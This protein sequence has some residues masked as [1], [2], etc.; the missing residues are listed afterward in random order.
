MAKSQTTLRDERHQMTRRALIKW[1]VAAGA[2][3][4]VS[5][6]KVFEILEKTAGKGVAMAASENPTTRSVHI[7]AGNGALAWFTLF[8]PQVD[9]ANA[10]NPNFAWHKPGQQTTVAGTT[11]PLV[12]G[13]DTPWQKLA[14]AQQVTAFLCGQ[15]ETHN[16]QPKSTATLNGSNIFAVASALQSASPSVIPVVTIGDQSVG[17]AAGQAAVSNVGNADGITALFNSAASRAGGLLSNMN[18]A[19]TYKTYYDAFSQLNRARAQSTVQTSYQTAG[20]AATFLGTNLA[21]KLQVTA[22]DLTRYGVN[23]GTRASL[24]AVARTLIITA[25][26]FQLG[27]TNSVVF[28]AFRDDP[29]NA[30]DGGDVNT[31]PAA[32]KTVFDG[33]MTD[34]TNYT[35]SATGQTLKDDT[36]ISVHG[37]TMKNCRNKAGWGDGTDGNT[38]TVFVYGAGHLYSGWNGSIDRNGKVLGYGTDGKPTTYD[39]NGTAKIA[40]AAIAYAIAKRDDRLIQTFANGTTIGGVFGPLKAT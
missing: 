8:W 31:I 6:A 21:S 13:P 19:T 36:V 39:P 10:G 20:G 9:I 22:D 12:I 28:P 35:D 32:M 30:F 16:N 5:R 27:L 14:P 15:N 3:L 23:A 29:H 38:N 40:T 25:K 34:L 2:A 33:F 11:N 4:G 7:C 18:D 24:T 26:A 17:T 37:D 1:S